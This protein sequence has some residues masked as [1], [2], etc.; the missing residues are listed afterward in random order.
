[1]LKII[2][3]I[4]H[5]EITYIVEDDDLIKSPCQGRVSLFLLVVSSFGIFKHQLN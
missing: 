5:M 3:L 1:M 2:D 4:I